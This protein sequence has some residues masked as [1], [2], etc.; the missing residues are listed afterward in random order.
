MPPQSGRRAVGATQGG[1]SPE[2]GVAGGPRA[3]RIGPTVELPIASIVVGERIRRVDPAMVAN[4]AVA[5]EESD[6]FGAILVRPMAGNPR[7]RRYELVVGAHRL[8]AM[9]SLGRTTIPCTIRSLT[10]DQARLLEIDENLVR[11]KLDILEEGEA[12]LAR[13][14]VFGRIFPDRVVQGGAGVTGKRGRPKNSAKF[15]ELNG[16]VPMTMGFSAATAAEIGMSPRVV[17][18]RL[19]IARLPVDIREGIRATWVADSE[20]VLRQLVAITDKAQQAAAV[21]VLLS[22]KTKSVADALA[23]AAGGAPAKAERAT[24][25]ALQTAFMKLWKTAN[26]GDRAEV[27]TWLSRQP[28][29]PGD[30]ALI[31][32]DAP[33]LA[34][35]RA[36][37]NP[38]PAAE[39]PDLLGF[40][41]E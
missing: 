29:V 15:A 7:L 14:E 24:V 35:F 2:Q 23:Y 22:G 36:R 20:G 10:D 38:A 31:P 13:Y 16:G 18:D 17:R 11:G 19:L 5:I 27:L 9:T 33:E 41:D 39:E 25:S 3:S 28:A 30:W 21:E 1:E 34:A 40:D 6:F 12:L 32:A 26:G 37:V 8:A 4:L